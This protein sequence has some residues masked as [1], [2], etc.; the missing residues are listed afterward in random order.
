MGRVGGEAP[1]LGEGALQ[2]VE[3][4]VE[5]ADQRRQLVAPRRRRDALA[6]V[7]GPDP[8][9]RGMDR[10]D[11]PQGQPGE[12]PAQPNAGE[13]D[14]GEQIEADPRVIIQQ[15][16]HRLQRAGDLD[17]ERIV[18]EFANPDRPDG[19]QFDRPGP[20]RRTLPRMRHNFARR[21]PSPR[22]APPA[23]G[24]RPSISSWVAPVPAMPAPAGKGEPQPVARREYEQF[25]ICYS[26]G[27]HLGPL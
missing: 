19:G 11:R 17:V 13:R 6:E 5:Q 24:L 2:P 10:P 14:A 15:P 8:A 3:H 12:G 16:P 18:V 23:P 22:T 7:V 1:D 26:R 27:V 4:P 20:P 25:F 9:R 21:A